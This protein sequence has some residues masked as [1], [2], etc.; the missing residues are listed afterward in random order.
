MLYFNLKNHFHFH[1]FL[2]KLLIKILYSK[3]SNISFSID[4]M[5]NPLN[6]L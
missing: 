3:F 1:F 5:V 4:N 2:K 6:F